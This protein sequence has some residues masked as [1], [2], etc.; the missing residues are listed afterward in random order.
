[1]NTGVVL[2]EGPTICEGKVTSCEQTMADSTSWGLIKRELLRRDK[3][4]IV[5]VTPLHGPRPASPRDFLF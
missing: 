5:T 2:K 3:V 1:M 4:G